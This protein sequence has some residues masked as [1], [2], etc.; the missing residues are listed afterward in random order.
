VAQLLRDSGLGYLVF[1]YLAEVTMSILARA[2]AQDSALGYATDFVSEVL[3]QNLVEIARQ[4]VKV[5]ST[6]A[7]P[8]RSA[9]PQP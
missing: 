4:G 2:R 1:D 6:A 5:I 3:R 8:I 7:A 9:V